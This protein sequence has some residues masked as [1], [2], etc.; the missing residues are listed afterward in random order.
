[1]V[2]PRP[3]RCSA[4]GEVLEIKD[5]VSKSSDWSSA[6]RSA[7]WVVAKEGISIASFGAIVKDYTDWNF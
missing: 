5:D 3:A 1:L 7:S 6:S 2:M 4:A